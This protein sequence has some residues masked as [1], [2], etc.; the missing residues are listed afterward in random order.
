MLVVDGIELVLRDQMLEVRK[1]DG[2]R[3][4]RRQQDLQSPYEIIDVVHLRQHVV[5][6]QQVGVLPGSVS[7]VWIGGSPD[8]G[9]WRLLPGSIAHVAVFTNALSAAQLLAL[10]GAGTN[11]TPNIS[12]NLSGAEKTIRLAWRGTLLQAANLTGPWLSNLSVS[13]YIIA[14]TNAQMFFRAQ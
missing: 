9:T 8:Y 14:P 1:L 5:T 2:D 13:P 6:Q 10:Y 4:A 3:A 7:D 12:L 11:T